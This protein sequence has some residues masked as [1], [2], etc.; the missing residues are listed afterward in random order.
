MS[1]VSDSR[2]SV[3]GELDFMT[4]SMT[5]LLMYHSLT[6]G[7]PPSTSLAKY[8][9]DK[10]LFEEHLALLKENA[11]VP[12]TMEDYLSQ[13]LS[14][15]AR[16][17]VL[18]F[19]HAF[20]DFELALPL[21]E[22]YSFK[23]TLFVPTAFVGGTS[24]WLSGRD[25]KHPLLSW[26]DLR[27][28]R[29]VEIAAHGHK[30]L[31]LDGV[32]LEVARRDMVRGKETLEDKLGK[33]VVSFAYPYGSYNEAVKGLVREAGFMTACTTEE[34]L[35]T[36]QDDIFALPR[37]TVAGGMNADDLADVLEAKSSR[38]SY[39][40]FKTKL[41]RNWRRL[42]SLHNLQKRSKDVENKR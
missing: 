24:R 20:A 26:N 39:Q 29:G 19:D 13:G 14:L 23:A 27:E 34:R 8:S 22:K 28:L 7:R 4:T 3:K 16:G 12:L 32:P 15:S 11:F 18:T 35:S 25:A 38:G 6:S 33:R 30:Y 31:K 42:S 37:L 2:N 1:K 41:W 17:V 36:R 9:V 5:P 21:L 40:V 10:T